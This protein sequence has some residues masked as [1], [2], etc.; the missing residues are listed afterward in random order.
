VIVQMETGGTLIEIGIVTENGQRPEV[1]LLD[2]PMGLIAQ[3]NRARRNIFIAAVFV[4]GTGTGYLL[5]VHG[6]LGSHP[7]VARPSMFELAPLPGPAP[8]P[9]GVPSR[10][11]GYGHGTLPDTTPSNA[12]PQQ[13]SG[14]A[15]ADPNHQRKD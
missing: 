2:P 11:P 15:P 10:A 9:G 3:T 12:A 1:T 13:P 8:A 6:L 5:T 7:D 4:T 14:T